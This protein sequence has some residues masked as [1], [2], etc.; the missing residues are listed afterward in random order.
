MK[1]RSNAF[2][3][4]LFP[5]QKFFASPSKYKMS[6][7]CLRPLDVGVVDVCDVGDSVSRHL[8]QPGCLL[9]PFFSCVSNF[10]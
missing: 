2:L 10:P 4:R 3:L 5:S 7:G 1:F 9:L 8:M 6:K